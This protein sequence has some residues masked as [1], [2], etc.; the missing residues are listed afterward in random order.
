MKHPRYSLKISYPSGVT[1]YM[2]YRGRTSWCYTQA[3]KHLKEWV[4]L[5]GVTIEMEESWY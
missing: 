3:K 1:S 4:Y 5:H 2:S